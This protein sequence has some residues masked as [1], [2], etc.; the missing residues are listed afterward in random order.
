MSRKSFK[1]LD[2]HMIKSAAMDSDK[3]IEAEIGS[4][5]EVSLVEHAEEKDEDQSYIETMES[6]IEKVLEIQQKTSA[7]L[8]LRLDVLYKE[9]NG[10]IETLDAHV[11]MLDAHVSQTAKVVKKQE[12]LVKGKAVESEMHQVDAI[13]DNNFGEV[14]IIICIPY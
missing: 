9:L 8:N 1:N 2:M 4:I 13:S 5:P 11:M 6:M 10:Q 12:A 14:L 7:S 3:I